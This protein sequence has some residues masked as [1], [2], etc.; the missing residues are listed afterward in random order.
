MQRVQA[1]GNVAVM[2]APSARTQDPGY[3]SSG[4]PANGVLGT[5]IPADWLNA[6][7][8]EMINVIISAGLEPDADD[9]TQ[10]AQSIRLLTGADEES[11]A[12]MLAEVKGL[13]A[14]VRAD[15][16]AAESSVAG[17]AGAEGRCAESAAAAVAAQNACEASA[18]EAL[19]SAQSV[20]GSASLIESTNAAL[21]QAEADI[22]ANRKRIENMYAVLNGVAYQEVVDDS[23]AYAKTVGDDTVTGG[24]AVVPYLGVK[25]LGGR[26]L[27]WRQKA[28][29]TPGTVEASGVTWVIAADGSYTANGTASALS[30]VNTYYDSVAGHKYLLRGCPQGGGSMW[31]MVVSEGFRDEGAGVVFTSAYTGVRYI[32]LRVLKGNTAE[33]VVFWPQLYDL[34]ELF[35]EGNE[36]ATPEEFS[37]IFPEAFYP[38]SK[39]ELLSA[40]VVEVVSTDADGVPIGTLTIPAEVQALEGYGWSTPTVRNWIDWERRIYHQE[41]G[42]GEYMASDAEDA[43]VITNG[44]ITYYPLTSPKQVDISGMIPED[45]LIAVQKG[46]TLTFVNQHGNRFRIPV[47]SEIEYLVDLKAEGADA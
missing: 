46:G 26:T 21:S 19:A 1:P 34:T 14:A 10:F 12:A 38:Y 7:Q 11:T 32:I 25:S 47:P 16:L 29:V 6:L 3:F 45:N 15:R 28:L 37:A 4:D 44:T 42:S 18:A 39:G 22:A 35:G 5:R 23:T 9:L 30:T 43:S 20:A 2:P 8:E 36:P 24:A 13:A 40:G 27:L 41:V 33:N 31:N 17:I